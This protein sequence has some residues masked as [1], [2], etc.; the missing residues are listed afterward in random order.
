[1]AT[2]E[3]RVRELGLEIPDY[4]AVPYHGLHYGSMK[5]YHQTGNLLFL[6]G[7]VADLPG[8]DYAATLIQTAQR[9]V[10]IAFYDATGGDGWT[11]NSGWKTPPLYPDGFAMRSVADNER[12]AAS[13]GINT[14]RVKRNILIISAIMS[15]MSCWL[16]Q[17]KATI[18][19]S[20]TSGSW[21]ASSL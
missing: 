5:A 18:C 6:S 21:R 9:R 14:A 16:A 2:P 3:E 8:Q 10:L 11:D 12:A 1:M 17:L 20:D 15:S 19:S 13:V 7:H 4:T